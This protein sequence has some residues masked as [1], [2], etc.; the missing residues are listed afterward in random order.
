M[1]GWRTLADGVDLAVEAAPDSGS[2][3]VYAENYGQAGAI[4]YYGRSTARVVSFSDSYRLWAPDRLPPDLRALVYVNSELGADVDSL[5]GIVVPMGGVTEPTARERGTSVWLC[6]SPQPG[7]YEHYA[8]RVAP[9][10]QG[11]PRPSSRP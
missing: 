5:F 1:Q 6:L 11:L 9:V 7:F 4:E 3:V 2:I 8:R 10:K